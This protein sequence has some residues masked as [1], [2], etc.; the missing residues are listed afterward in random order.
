MAEPLWTPSPERIERANIP[1]VARERGLSEDYSAL[2]RWSV[3]NL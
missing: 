3:E 1:R 2:W